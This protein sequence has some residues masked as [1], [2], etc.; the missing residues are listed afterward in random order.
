MCYLFSKSGK[1]M[2]IMKC[3][4]CVMSK[5]RPMSIRVPVPLQDQASKWAEHLGMD[6]ASVVTAL[7]AGF[8]K[9]M[10][11]SGGKVMMPFELLDA[12]SLT[13][14]AH[15]VINGNQG[16]VSMSDHG[17]TSKASSRI[18]KTRGKR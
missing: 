8:V 7:I 13:H 14:G 12:Y 1:R 17:S 18:R 6:K 4:E 11:R 9:S 2:A 16:P 3:E 5:G 10:D 15:V